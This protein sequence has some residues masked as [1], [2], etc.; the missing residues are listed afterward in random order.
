MRLLAVGA[1]GSVPV[2]LRQ[3]VDD[4][5]FR[6]PFETPPHELECKVDLLRRDLGSQTR[7]IGD[8]SPESPLRSRVPWSGGNGADLA[9]DPREPCGARRIGYSLERRGPMGRLLNIVFNK[10]LWGSVK[11]VIG[12]AAQAR[13]IRAV[14]RGAGCCD[15]DRSDPDR[16]RDPAQPDGHRSHCR[17]TA[18]H[19][20]RVHPGQRHPPLG[21]QSSY[22]CGVSKPPSARCG[23]NFGAPQARGSDDSAAPSR[24]SSRHCARP[25]FQSRR[26]RRGPSAYR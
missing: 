10:I 1:V 3:R 5:A 26:H 12:P 11:A 25:R 22:T 21:E 16:R 2:L 17:R 24:S 20:R 8:P 13:R 7:P 23:L 19:H 4:A 14:D 6:C 15:R 9:G 18:R